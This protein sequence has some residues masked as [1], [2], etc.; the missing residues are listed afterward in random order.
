MPGSRTL[1]ALAG[2]LASL[3]VSY[4]VWYYFDTLLLFLFVPFVPILLRGPARGEERGRAVR[5]C[6]AC[7]FR[8]VDPEYDY[9]P[10]DRTRLE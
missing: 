2:L 3:A 1:T 9:C 10:R 8:T 4:V 5:T 7:G 6:P